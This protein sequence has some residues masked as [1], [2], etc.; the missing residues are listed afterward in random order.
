M[1]EIFSRYESRFS[2]MYLA[3]NLNLKYRLQTTVIIFS[4]YTRFHTFLVE[5]KLNAK[6]LI[7]VWTS[8]NRLK[9]V[10]LIKKHFLN[11]LQSLSE[12]I[13][14]YSPSLTSFTANSFQERKNH[15]WIFIF[16]RAIKRNREDFTET[17]YY[18][19][20][21]LSVMNSQSGKLRA[22]TGQRHRGYKFLSYT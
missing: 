19:L 21:I 17:V 16:G 2:I 4:N 13:V 12:K 7:Y 3:F 14:C 22:D 5:R 1:P 9:F 11:F 8:L 18:I 6:W 10:R 15:R 20:T